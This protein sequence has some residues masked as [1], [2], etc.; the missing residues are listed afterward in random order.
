MSCASFMFLPSSLHLSLPNMFKKIFC[1]PK[2]V[3]P[4]HAVA[5]LVLSL[6]SAFQYISLYF[7]REFLQEK[8]YRLDNDASCTVAYEEEWSL[9]HLGSTFSPHFAPNLVL[10]CARTPEK[11][12]C[13]STPT[14]RSAYLS[15]PYSARDASTDASSRATVFEFG[16]LGSLNSNRRSSGPR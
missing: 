12:Y 11:R 5:R 14:R 4:M 7:Q 13:C 15:T 3:M 16:S 10:H 2:K 8:A 9:F 1:L 6:R